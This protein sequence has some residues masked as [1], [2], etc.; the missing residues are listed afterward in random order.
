M[1]TLWDALDFIEKLLWLTLVAM[2]AFVVGVVVEGQAAE[3]RL[4]GA[5]ERLE[6]SLEA[7]CETEGGGDA[8]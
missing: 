8:E 7:G 2:V 5:I 3:E 4:R 1:R 6:R